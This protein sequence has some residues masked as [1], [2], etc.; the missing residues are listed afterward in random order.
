MNKVFHYILRQTWLMVALVMSVALTGCDKDDDNFE[1][2]LLVSAERVEASNLESS[3]TIDF[4]TNGAWEASVDVDWITLAETS[5]EKGK[6]KLLFTVA[7][8][9]DD[10]RRGTITISISE[11]N[12]IQVEVAQ[13]PGNRNDIYVKVDGTGDGTSWEQATTLDE[14]L[15]M[16]V[17]GNV[18]HIAAGLYLPGKTVSGGNA[19]DEGDK[20]FHIA[21]NITL[22]GGYPADASEGDEADPATHKTILS[23]SGTSYHVV[24]ISASKIQGQKA[25]LSGLTITDGNASSSSAAIGINGVSF[26]RNY[27]GGVIA[28]NTVAELVDCEVIANNS[29]G[30]CGGIYVFGNSEITIRNSKVNENSSSSN[31]GGAWIHTSTA[32]VYNSE[33]NGNSGGTAAGFHAY[34]DATAYLYNTTLAENKGRSY[35]AAFYARQNSRGVLVNCLITGNTSTSANGG[36]GVMMYQDCEVDIIS[37][38]ITG[39]VIS[40]PG[41]GV[42]RRAGTQNILSIQNSIISGNTQKD[43]GPDVD[44]YEVDAIAPVVRASVLGSLT[45]DGTGGEVGGA[46][47]DAATMFD[48]DYLPIGGSNPAIEYGMSPAQLISVGGSLNPPAEEEYLVIDRFGNERSGLT[49]MGAVVATP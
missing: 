25:V 37:T 4:L 27:G 17:D 26:V 23:G 29:R 7:A 5:G 12:S 31:G 41:G 22:K 8:N 16:A 45:Y 36:G 18:I 35:G 32:Y 46:T 47:F 11:S 40:G 28:G 15:S 38:T 14:A 3:Y 42:Y 34:P 6:H 19:A 49:T 1:P 43:D 21:R 44:A 13:D 10:E 48:S 2:K 33:F 9:E 30:H 24:L 20:S 39:N